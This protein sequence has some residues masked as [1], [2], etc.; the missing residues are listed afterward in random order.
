MIA[1][2]GLAATLALVVI[3]LLAGLSPT[4]AQSVAPITRSDPLRKEVLDTV[5]PLFRG[6]SG[7]DVEFVVHGLNVWGEWVFGDVKLQ[8][9]GGRA[10]DWRQSP[11]AEDARAGMF[12]PGSSFFLLLRVGDR[13]A[14]VD[15]ATGPTDVAWD[16]WRQQY[17]LPRDLF[18][19]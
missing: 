16:W 9:P 19:N 12:D 1:R 5:R 18:G 7:G 13:W 17:G 2:R 14:I 3:V 6:E 4:A 15:W 11:Y 10:I 8:H